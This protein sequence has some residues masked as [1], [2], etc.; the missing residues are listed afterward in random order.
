[1]SGNVELQVRKIADVERRQRPLGEK[2]RRFLEKN[3]E[4]T[5]INRSLEERIKALTDDNNKLVRFK[6]NSHALW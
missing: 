4:L 3:M 6:Q 5:S 1:M 2:A